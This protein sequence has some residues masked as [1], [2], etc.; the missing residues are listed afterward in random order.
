[1]Q[2]QALATAEPITGD[3]RLSITTTGGVV[4]DLRERPAG[5][6]TPPVTTEMR[7]PRCE[8]E[9]WADD[10]D[11]EL[12]AAQLRCTTCGLTFL[13]R[14]HGEDAG[15]PARRHRWLG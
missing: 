9:L 1:M 14:L 5:D 6:L 11:M 10:V 12:L 7:C 8:S 13:Q 2:H 15:G 4:Y 3:V